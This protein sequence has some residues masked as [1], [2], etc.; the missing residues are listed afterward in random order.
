M[1]GVSAMAQYMSAPGQSYSVAAFKEPMCETLAVTD[2]QYSLAYGVATLVSGLSLPLTG[3]LLDRFGARVFLPIVGTLLSIACLVMSRAQDLGGLYLGFTMIRCLGQ[4]ALT[5]VAMWMIGEWFR[6][7]RGF[8]TALAG[9]GG[10]ISVMTFP[11]LNSA[12]IAHFGWQGAW[13]V[14]GLAVALVLIVP[15][16]LLVRDRPEPFGFLPDGRKPVAANGASSS[17]EDLDPEPA[18]TLAE[19]LRDPT[20][21]KLVSVPVT[22]GMVVTGMIFH[23]VSVLGSRGI[24]PQEALALLSL[25]ALV[26]T[27]AV[28]GAGWLSDR[29][30][31]RI[32]LSSA[33]ALLAT[34]VLAVLV[35][36]VPHLA[37]LY[38]V[39][40][41]LHG[42]ILRSAGTVVW[43]NFYGRK[44]QG[45]IRGVAMSL[46][47][48][49]AAVGPLPLAISNDR[50]ATYTPALLFFIGT[51]IVSGI[52]ALT[53]RPSVGTRPA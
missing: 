24:S 45:A 26:A 32:L 14:L 2:T 49:A 40:L 38:A 20:F 11:L 50:L 18:W 53:A 52:L 15:S 10:S 41:G 6:K 27:I 12:L 22:S 23:Q 47:I 48:L 46:M 1:V 4:G 8:A 29:V 5:L 13:V 30:S 35:M 34:S 33:M 3:K 25:Q 44:N 36:P 7:R 21:W 16:W 17:T 28:L 19:T 42:S 43:V 37:I 9:M 31:A 39:L 51:P